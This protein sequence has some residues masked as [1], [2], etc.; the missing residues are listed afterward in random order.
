MRIL[1][2]IHKPQVGIGKPQAY[3]P[4]ARLFG[5][6]ARVRLHGLQAK[7]G[8]KRAEQTQGLKCRGI[9]APHLDC[10]SFFVGIVGASRVLCGFFETGSLKP[11]ALITEILLTEILLCGGYCQ[12]PSFAETVICQKRYMGFMKNCRGLCGRSRLRVGMGVHLF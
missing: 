8:S 9:V 7:Q 12:V 1:Q 6:G 2:N 10:R 11:R 3:L 4:R 5:P